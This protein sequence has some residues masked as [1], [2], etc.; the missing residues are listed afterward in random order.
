MHTLP[1]L[2]AHEA[3]SNHHDC[4]FNCDPFS[5]YEDILASEYF[6]NI[7][8]SVATTY[9]PPIVHIPG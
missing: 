8:M 6:T 9:L 7:E 5:Y 2:E 3:R 1:T 4:K